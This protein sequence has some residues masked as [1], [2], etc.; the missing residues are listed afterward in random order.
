MWFDRLTGEPVRTLPAV[1]E[2]G[3][4]WISASSLTFNGHVRNFCGVLVPDGSELCQLGH[5]SHKFVVPE[6]SLLPKI[7]LF[8]RSV[9]SVVVDLKPDHRLHSP[10]M[11]TAVIDGQSHLLHIEEVLLDV[12]NKGHLHHISLRPRLDLHYED[13]VTDIARAKRLAKGALV[14]LASHSECWQRQSLSGVIPKKVLARFSEDDYNTYENRVYARLLDNIERHL[15]RRIDTL[16]QLQATLDQALELYEATD[17]NHRLVGDICRLWGQTFDE[18]ATNKASKVLSSTLETLEYLY[19]TT[20]GL[21]QAGLYLRVPRYVQ[22]V[23]S[24][25]LTNILS[26]D[27][28]YRHLPM[29]WDL[30][31]NI[32]GTSRRVPDEHCRINLSLAQAYSRYAGLTLAHALKP[33]MAGQEE[34]EWAGKIL[35]LKQVGLEWEL[36][37]SM[38]DL[39]GLEAEVLLTVV[40]WLSFTS[41]PDSVIKHKASAT[42]GNRVIAWPALDQLNI[43]V[44]HEKNL[45]ALSP[46]DLYCVERFGRLVDLVVWSQVIK[47]YGRPLNKIPRKVIDS[48]LV[49]PSLA[50]KID[51]AQSSLYIYEILPRKDFVNIQEALIANNAKEQAVELG[52]RQQEIHTMQVCPVCNARVKLTFQQPSGFRANCDGCRTERYFRKHEKTWVFEQK[53]EGQLEFRTVGRRGA[54]ASGNLA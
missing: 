35:R 13:E 53:L 10:L 50:L 6:T 48:I 33:Y 17:L 37:S 2:P 9:E 51:V 45:I 38:P 43:R 49:K 32:H 5:E 30:L 11:P 3:R 36:T 15:R 16:K 54:Y 28:H 29:I 22:V 14:H 7:E 39:P 27:S 4:Y 21:K 1:V 20:A 26:H 31:S 8:S 23:G 47:E 41:C 19:K 24:L 18:A 25:H 40:P 42:S 52:L 46:F 34:V 12:V 44:A